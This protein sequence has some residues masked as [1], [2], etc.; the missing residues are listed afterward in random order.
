MDISAPPAVLP[1]CFGVF[2]P[3]DCAP[4]HWVVRGGP[5]S[6]SPRWP[7]AEPATQLRNLP[8]TLPT[9]VPP[10]EFYSSLPSSL[11]SDST[12]CSRHSTLSRQQA[13]V[14]LESGALPAAAPRG[15][16][17]RELIGEPLR[18]LRLYQAHRRSP[19]PSCHLVGTSY[20]PLLCLT[21][22]GRAIHLSAAWP[23]QPL[24]SSP[25]LVFT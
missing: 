2:L 6:T 22:S 16:L 18:S 23:R 13:S 11:G 3:G 24:H 21:S 4:L 19:T 7:L 25:H 5:A 1:G 14:Y 17:L 15:H 10:P 9:T 8:S 12:I 20:S